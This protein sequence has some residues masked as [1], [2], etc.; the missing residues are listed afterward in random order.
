MLAG[1]MSVLTFHILHRAYVCLVFLQGFL[2]HDDQKRR[3]ETFST[4]A[5]LL[6][7]LLSLIRPVFLFR[8]TVSPLCR[9]GRTEIVQMYM[10]SFCNRIQPSSEP[11]IHLYT[12]QHVRESQFGEKH[13]NAFCCQPGNSVTSQSRSLITM[14]RRN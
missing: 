1:K 11:D 10:L 9:V 7:R 12:K 6:A 8:L 14:K 13:L 4:N 2:T 3:K 5:D